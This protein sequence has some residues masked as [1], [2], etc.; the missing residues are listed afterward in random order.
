M[1]IGS[2]IRIKEPL[3]MYKKTYP[4]GHEFTIFGSSGFR[5]WDIIDDD[6]NKIYETLFSNNTFEEI[7][8]LEQRK[9]K[10]NKIKK[11][12]NENTFI[13]KTFR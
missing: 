7:T 9:N 2:R 10:I 1:K 8:L 3:E 6:G 11:L 5:G 13:K 4:I 12:I